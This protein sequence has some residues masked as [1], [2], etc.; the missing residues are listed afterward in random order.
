MEKCADELDYA[1]EHESELIERK[2]S[3]IRSIQP[4]A[5]STGFCLYCGEEQEGERRWC[6]ATCRDLWEAEKRGR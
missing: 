2:V 4:V 5:T 6:D 1:Q 3:Q